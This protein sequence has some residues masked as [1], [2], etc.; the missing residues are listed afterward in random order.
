MEKPRN[1]RISEVEETDIGIYVWQVP[2]GRWVGD[3]EG[4]FLSINSKKGDL[5]RIAEITAA[6]RACGVHE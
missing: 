6:A 5:R 3:D 2:D 1:V 4:N